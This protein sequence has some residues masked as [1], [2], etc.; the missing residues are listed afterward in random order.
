MGP[1]SIDTTI[2]QGSTE[3]LELL[4]KRG[5]S[6]MYRDLEALGVRHAYVPGLLARQQV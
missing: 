4:I 6:A 3:I 5:G 2:Q 1:I